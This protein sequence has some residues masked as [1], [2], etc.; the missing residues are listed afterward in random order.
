MVFDEI[1]EKIRNILT[2][3]QKHTN[4][5]VFDKH[6]AQA[7]GISSVNLASMKCRGQVPYDNILNF[8]AKR[9]I[10]IN[11]LLFNQDPAAMVDSTD[12]YWI[13]CYN[14]I[15]ASAG[16]GACLIEDDECK[17]NKIE[18]DS[19]F[20]NSLMANNA[21]LKY[22]EA[23]RVSGDSMEPSLY[24]GDIVF[25]DKSKTNYHKSGIYIILYENALFVKR[26]KQ[27]DENSI[28]IISDNKEYPTITTNKNNIEV[29]G[30]IIASFCSV[31]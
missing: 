11:W 4:K 3:E 9:K 13:N 29:L 21:N 22:T 24:D 31:F 23:I 15:N 12:K 28:E 6:I 17:D 10:S 20:A 27:I 26:L 16:G 25:V 8:C 1:I 14:N 18:I 2:M 7:L 19:C 30:K 5:K